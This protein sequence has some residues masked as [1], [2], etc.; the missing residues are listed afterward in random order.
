MT[1]P[2]RAEQASQFLSKQKSEWDLL[3]AGHEHLAQARMREFHFDGFVVKLQFNPGRMIS[4]SAPVD[5]QSIRARPCFLCRQNRPPEQKELPLLDDLVLLCNPYPILPEHFTLVTLTH[6]PQAIQRHVGTMLDLARVLGSRYTVFYNG[7][8]CGASAPDHLH[9]Q[10][11]TRGFM[12]LDAE[13]SRLPRT[14]LSNHHGAAVLGVDEYLRRLLVI[15]GTDRDSVMHAFQRIERALRKFDSNGD[16]PMF[17]IIAS[18]ESKA[19]K[20]FIFPRGRHRPSFY[21]ADGDARILLSPAA[22]DMGGVCITPVENDFLRL[23]RSQIVEMF[24][25]VTLP[26]A[27]WEQVIDEIRSGRSTAT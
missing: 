20:V 9:F 5:E 1:P 14:L 27:T 23:T 13:Y 2:D 26:R 22:V 10:A 4:T 3:R 17:N 7:P 19:W 16:E 11:G 12:P 18:H 6:S 8:R 21:L 25:E 24:D 15:E